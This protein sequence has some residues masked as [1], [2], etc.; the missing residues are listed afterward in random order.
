[1]EG[2]RHP[3]DLGVASSL[4]CRHTHRRRQ[5][6]P[7]HVDQ[8]VP[9]CLRQIAQD[10]CLAAQILLWPTALHPQ[11]RPRLGVVVAAFDGHRQAVVRPV[12]LVLADRGQADSL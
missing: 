8:Q 11:E 1:M 4:A 2:R 10:L 12:L 5:G 6:R 7:D 3:K 9:K